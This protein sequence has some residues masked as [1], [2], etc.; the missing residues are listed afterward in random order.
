MNDCSTFAC[1]TKGCQSVIHLHHDVEEK[2]RETHETFYCPA[3]HFNYFPGKTDEQRKLEQAESLRDRFRERWHEALEE[4]EEWKLQA[5]RCPFGCGFRVLRKSKP[6]SVEL[7][8]S[9]HLVEEHGAEFP[10]EVD[11]TAVEA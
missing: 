1:A 6:E 2:L 7:A 11:R 3:G 10:A 8:L 9:L 5:K 4:R